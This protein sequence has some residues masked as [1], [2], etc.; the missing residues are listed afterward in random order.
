MN[1]TISQYRVLRGEFGRNKER[2]RDMLHSALW[3]VLCV[4]A[5][6]VMWAY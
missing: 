6:F 4:A 3:C 2:R 1:H 5:V